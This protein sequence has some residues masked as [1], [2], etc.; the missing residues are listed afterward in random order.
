MVK[1]VDTL[2]RFNRSNC[3][4]YCCLII[5]SQLHQK[6]WLGSFRGA[7]DSSFPQPVKPFN[8]GPLPSPSLPPS[9]SHFCPRS[10]MQFSF[11]LSLISGFHLS[12]LLS[13][14]SYHSC[15]SL[16]FL[17]SVLIPPWCLY[18]FLL[19]ELLFSSLILYMSS[20][21][22]WHYS[23]AGHVDAGKST[24]MGH[25]LYLL[26]NVNK[27]TMHKYEQESKKAG[28]ASFAYAWVLDE[29]GEE[30]DRYTTQA[31]VHK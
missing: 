4:Q 22:L 16:P 25:L 9:S 6:K 3:R 14:L 10:L 18:L 23:F 7:D 2:W 21:A 30:R 8:D 31:N 11:F 1:S 17:W 19:S 20:C 26:G 27:R 5:F 12:Y 29:T 28:K 24:L 15:C 13:L